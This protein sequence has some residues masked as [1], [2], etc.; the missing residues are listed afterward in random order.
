MQAQRMRQ[1]FGIFGSARIM[2]LSALFFRRSSEPQT[3]EIVFEQ[4]VYLVRLRR[5]RQ[6]RRYTL[7]IRAAS[8]EI[9][10]TMPLRGSVR[11]AKIFAQKHGGWIAA[12]LQRLPVATPFGHDMIL[13]VR[14]L[15]HRIVHHPGKRGTVWIESNASGERLLCVAG[16]APHIERRIGDFLKREAKRELETASRRAAEQ[17]GVAVKRVSVRD[18]SSR[19]GSCSTTGVLS[20]SW[21]LIFAPTFVLDYLAAHE[22]THLI[23]MNHSPRFWG[24][25]GQLCP[26]VK[27]AKAWLDA[28]GS[29]LHRYG[30]SSDEVQ[31]RATAI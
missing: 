11:E 1:S 25:V 30:L 2:P 26:D 19:W 5:H 9:V 17:L 4:M 31:P 29:D 6:A 23:E 16:G 18:Q 15:A 22:V 3:I 10:V 24:L 20:F 7:R 14:G 13:P 21:R 28:H 12:R 27:R 8:R